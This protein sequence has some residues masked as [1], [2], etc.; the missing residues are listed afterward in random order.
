M[1]ANADVYRADDGSVR[2]TKNG[3][4]ET[5][6]MVNVARILFRDLAPRDA[7]KIPA[8]GSG[9]LLKEGDFV[10]GEFKSL[11]DG[12]VTL[13]S[14]V[15]GL[16]KFD[17]RS[18]VAALVIN[19][20]DPQ[21]AA[22]IVRTT[23][24]STYAVKRLTLDRNRVTIEDPVAGPLTVDRAEVSELSIGPGRTEPLASLRPAKVEPAPDALSV[25]LAVA[26]ALNGVTAE[27]GV[28]LTAGSS[29]TWSL[30]GKYRALTLT[31]GVPAGVLPTTP[32]RFVVLADG[33]K[34]FRT[35]PRTSL[36]DPLTASLN[37]TGVKSLTLR[38]EST[39]PD[40]LPTPGVWLDPS[41]IK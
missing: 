32:V 12:Q 17:L 7:A 23:D 30:D 4:G 5:I 35:P 8:T 29:A 21:R 16:T 2:Y 13:S 3:R 34:L 28:A 38:V 10:E 31:C 27:R 6:S 37:V 33:K 1:L 40:P 26:A 36:S 39:S 11:R 22:S 20:P 24:G 18:K 19:D 15:F 25:S 9:V 14:V 41:L